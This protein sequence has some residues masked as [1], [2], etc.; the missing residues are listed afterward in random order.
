MKN[1]QTGFN[2]QCLCGN[3]KYEA[4]ATSENFYQCSCRDC[5][6][7]SGGLASSFVA[8][9]AKTFVL[10]QGETAPYTKLTDS[11]NT[12][13]RH[14]CANCGTQVYSQVSSRAGVSFVKA[15]TMNM[16]ETLKLKAQ[17]WCSSAQPWALLDAK[18]PQLKK[19]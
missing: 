10:M 6:Y 14:F 17:L 15:G 16:P 12:A 8:I 7:I 11:G 5:Q 18:A 13:T 4:R 19:N 1:K 3:I 9:P 2:G